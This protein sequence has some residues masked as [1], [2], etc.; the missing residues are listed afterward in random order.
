MINEIIYALKFIS[1]C[2]G[3]G[4]L[5]AWGFQIGIR[6]FFKDMKLILQL[7]GTN[8][9]NLVMKEEVHDD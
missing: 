7:N 1:T 9:F 2:F 4:I 5:I 3:I 8:N 6:R